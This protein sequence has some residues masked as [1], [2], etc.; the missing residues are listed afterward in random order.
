MKNI[1]LSVLIMLGLITGCASV[2]TDDINIETEADTKVNLS[3]YKTYA[4]LGSVG[5][6]NDPEGHWEPPAFDADAEIVFLVDKVLRKNGMT[7]VSSEPDLMVAYALGVD[8]EALE[9][10]QN[11]DTKLTTLENIPGAGLV[12]ILIDPDTGFVTWIGVATGE[13]KNQGSDIAKK[14][15]EYV[16]NTMFKG[17][18]K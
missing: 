9:L 10:K 15:L 4:W 7:E 11:P 1:I 14:R 17:I 18:P 5:I 3:G 8:M 6:V 2:P 13:I 12:M 16:I